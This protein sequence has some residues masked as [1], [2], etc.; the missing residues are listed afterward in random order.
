MSKRKNN[1]RDHFENEFKNIKRSLR[2]VYFAHCSV[3]NCEI[4]LEVIE[5]TAIS[6]PNAT[7]K[8]KKCARIIDSNKSMQNFFTRPSQPTTT[9]YKAAA[10]ESR[11]LGH[12]TLSNNNNHY[13]PITARP[14]NS[15]QFFLIQ[16]LQRSLLLPE[17][18]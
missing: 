16:T 18:R 2:G 12:T 6:A 1:F 14:N 17:Q 3:C 4:S 8:H 9:D 10:V 7:Q 11:L 5:K 13:V 15:K